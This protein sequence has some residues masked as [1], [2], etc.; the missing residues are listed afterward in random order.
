MPSAQIFYFWAI[1]ACP[2][3]MGLALVWVLLWKVPARY[4]GAANV[5]AADA[6]DP[7]QRVEP[8]AVAQ[9][10]EIAVQLAIGL[11][12]AVVGGLAGWAYVATALHGG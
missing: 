5:V 2:I 8:P 6:D 4:S 1:A 3:L 9:R 7:L 11:G 12:L 10:R